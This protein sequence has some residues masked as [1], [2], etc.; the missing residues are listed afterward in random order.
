M[1]GVPVRRRQMETHA[2]EGT[3]TTTIDGREHEVGV[4]DTVFI[5]RGSVHHHQNLGE[6]AARAL[7]ALTP[8][9]IGRRYFEEMA[10]L[11]NAPGKPDEAKL[12]E[13][14]MRHGLV[15]A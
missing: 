1:A 6:V 14:M 8:G 7:T 12:R 2:Q 9:R 5:P 10:E 13:I 11:I 15:P 3:L 4:G